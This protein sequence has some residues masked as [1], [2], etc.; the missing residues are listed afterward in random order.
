M[1]MVRVGL[2]GSGF[3]DGISVFIFTL[4]PFVVSCG[5]FIAAFWRGK[6]GDTPVTPET[7]DVSGVSGV[8]LQKPVSGVSGIESIL[9]VFFMILS[10]WSC[11]EFSAIF[12]PVKW[13]FNWQISG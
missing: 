12:P 9:L 3:S 2:V 10:F 5:G 6:R 1:K 4:V 11:A 7:K 13:G 8:E